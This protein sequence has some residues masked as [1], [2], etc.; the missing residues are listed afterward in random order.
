MAN[1]AETAPHELRVPLEDG[2]LSVAAC[3]DAVIHVVFAPG[4]VRP[5]P[6]VPAAL[7]DCSQFGA[8]VKVEKGEATLSTRSLR[9]T[10]SRK[11]GRLRFLDANNQA[12]LE[13]P[14]LGGRRLK[15]KAIAGEPTLEPQ[16]LFLSPAGESFYGLGQRQ[17]GYMDW[18][19]IPVRMQQVDT[20]IAVPVVLS[21]RGYGI[22]WNNPAR[23]DFNPTDQ[24]VKIDP[25]TGQAVFTTGEEGSYGFLAA[26][27]TGRDD[28]ALTES[29]II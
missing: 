16:Q 25:K 18:R 8:R 27:G 12:I 9:V 21:T 29:R 20:Q 7:H 24:E 5:S 15:Q 1:L 2:T 6:R 13:E 4:S 19:G 22:F 14:E 23:T 11:T 10:V 28:I 3:G 17:E 26:G